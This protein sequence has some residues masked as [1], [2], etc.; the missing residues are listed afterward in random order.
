MSH[1]E[2]PNLPSPKDIEKRAEERLEQRAQLTVVIDPN[3]PYMTPYADRELR[4]E[5]FG[6]VLGIEGAEIQRA[7]D[8]IG[9]ILV[10]KEPEE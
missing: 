2:R 9:Y 5:A 4:A 1:E 3:L 8:Y 6:M 7:L 10:R